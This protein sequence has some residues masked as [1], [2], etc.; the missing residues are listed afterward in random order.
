MYEWQ[1]DCLDVWIRNGGR[2][3][4]NVVTGRENSICAGGNSPAGKPS[5]TKKQLESQSQDSRP[6][7]VSCQSMV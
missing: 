2:G 5:C 7:G 3:I 1:K 4:V 6:K